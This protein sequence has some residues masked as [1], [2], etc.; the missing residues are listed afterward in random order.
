MSDGREERIQFCHSGVEGATSDVCA[1]P[2]RSAGSI[3]AAST[4]VVINGVLVSGCEDA[5]RGFET[6]VPSAACDSCRHRNPFFLNGLRSVVRLSAAC[7]KK[8]SQ[9]ELLS[10]LLTDSVAAYGPSA[11]DS[12]S[13]LWRQRAIGAAHALLSCHASWLCGGLFSCFASARQRSVQCCGERFEVLHRVAISRIGHAVPQ[14]LG[15]CSAANDQRRVGRHAGL[16]Q[17]REFADEIQLLANVRHTQPEQLGL[18][19]LDGFH[20]RRERNR[21]AQRRRVE[22]TVAQHQLRHC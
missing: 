6:H 13:C 3:P 2:S 11:A 10:S 4:L 9:A 12:N 5:G 21:S 8:R 17:G 16:R 18:R 22:T 7:L 19:L 1:S 20:Q 14:L 15:Q